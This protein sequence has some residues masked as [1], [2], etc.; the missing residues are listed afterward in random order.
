MTRVTES[1][2][3]FTKDIDKLETADA[4]R[5]INKEDKAVAAVI[6]GLIDEIAEVTERVFQ[7]ISAGGRL[8]YVGTGTSGRLGLLDAAELPPTFGVAPDLVI[9]VIAGGYDALYKAVEA[10][11]DDRDAGVEDLKKYKLDREDAV[12]G[13]AASGSTP[14]TIGAVEFARSIGCF[15]ACIT[16]NPDSPIESA[17]E[18]PIVAVVGPE[19]IAGSTRMKAGTAQKLIL[20]MISTI[21]MVKLGFVTGNRMTNVR[22]TNRKLVERSLWLLRKETGISGE[23]AKELF[24]AAG[25]DL[26]VAIVM[27]KAGV[28]RERAEEELERTGNVIA[29]ALDQLSG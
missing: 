27:K 3:P 20:N 28:N 22:A 8:F 14:Y 4:L 21:L 18:K 10:S 19:A 11:E 6:S 13:I 16:C 25:E 5:L 15:T 2:N 29:V 12:I 1:E 24:R 23:K 26:R 9:G 17:V 7:C